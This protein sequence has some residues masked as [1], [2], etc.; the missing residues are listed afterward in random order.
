MNARPC[1]PEFDLEALR[2]F[3]LDLGGSEDEPLHFQLIPEGV[4]RKKAASPLL[5][6]GPLKQLQGALREANDHGYGVFF[7]VNKCQ[8]EQRKAENVVQVRAVFVDLDGAPLEPV[9]HGPLEPHYIIETSPGHYHVYWLVTDDFP[10]DR[11]KRVQKGLISVFDGDRAVCD[12][13][14]VMRL[15]GSINHKRGGAPVTI[16]ASHNIQRYTLQEIEAAFPG[17]DERDR[18]QQDQRKV[19]SLE[20]YRSPH[21]CEGTAAD[22]EK[23]LEGCKFIAHAVA[24]AESLPEPLWWSAISIV[25]HCTD[26][27]HLSHQIS[28][29]YPGYSK[30][31]TAIKIEQARVQGKPQTCSYIA[32]I[33]NAEFCDNCSCRGRIKSPISLGYRKCEPSTQPPPEVAALNKKHAMVMIEGKTAVLNEEESWDGRK[34]LTF[35]PVADFKYRYSNQQVLIPQGD[36]MRS[37]KLG[38]LW[39][40]SPHRRQYD[41]LV[42]VPGRE[43][44]TNFYN[45][46]RGFAVE[47]V[48]G[49]WSL[50]QRHIFEVIA[51]GNQEIYNYLLAYIARL[52]QDPGG[53]R[54]GVAL[55]LLGEQGTG[56]GEFVRNLGA[57]FGNH[58]LHITSE[59]QLSGRF[60]GHFA[61]TSLAYFDE[62]FWA[63]DKSAEGILKGLI[64]EPTISLEKKGKDAVQ[65]DNHMNL[66][67][68]SNNDWVVP[69]GLEERRFLVLKVSNRY[70]QDHAYFKALREQMDNGG[71]EAM[72]YD[73]LGV[74]I[75][76]VNLRQ[77]P[78]TQELLSQIV[79][80]LNSTER[81]WFESLAE[82]TLQMGKSFISALPTSLDPDPWDGWHATDWVHQAYVS[83]CQDH[84][85]RYPSNKTSFV[86]ALKRLCPS[87]RQQRKSSGDNRPMGYVFPRLEICRQEFEAVINI[88]FEWEPEE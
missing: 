14:R 31:E 74:D 53:D 35:S 24:D 65:I 78:R 33:T 62:A 5:R 27:D 54:P 73:L 32:E 67:F 58:F 77:V 18:D 6:V 70:R 46:F 1:K 45:L 51:D 39:L 56:K 47:P 23:I 9:Y 10:L 81:Y 13:P 26:G 44:P 20:S 29:P 36:K 8:G 38:D 3:L 63:G 43:V 19:V 82:G 69:A 4:L 49:D 37:V 48:Q 85:D 2:D 21:G 42:Y 72:L 30:H 15:P 17:D 88:T 28:R 41:R 84:G 57:I 40:D 80:S 59:H 75:S 76:K 50:M 68:S 7:A 25:A 22:F 83:Y 34:E 64:T 87:L 86:K 61:Q 66:I 60:N 16:V 55:V 52:Y 79:H 11:F 71:R 12:L